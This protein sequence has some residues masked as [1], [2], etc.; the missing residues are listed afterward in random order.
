MRWRLAALAAPLA[1]A[2]A[3]VGTQAAEAASVPT[4]RGINI[5]SVYG[6]QT[7]EQIDRELDLA[8]RLGSNA[9]RLT[10]DSATLEPSPGFADP[11]YLDR[12][13][14]V[15]NAASARGLKVIAVVMGTP[16]WASSAPP[17]VRRDCVNPD[18]F[19]VRYPPA[20]PATYAN[21]ASY[22]AARYRG[23][24]AALEV[25][26]EPDL[27]TRLYWRGPTPAG[28]YAR[29][30]RA[31]YP[32]IKAADPTLPV[33]GGSLVGSNGVFLRQLYAAGIRG[34][35]D[36]LAI[37]F[38]DVV[39]AGIRTIAAIKRTYH[40]T[41]PLWETEFGWDSCGPTGRSPTNL[42]CVTPT[43]QA[44]NLLDVFRGLSLHPALRATIVFNAIDN[45][46]IKFGAL[47]ETFAPK[48][49]FYALQAAFAGRAGAVRSPTMRLFR[50]RGA[51][52]ATGTAPAGD[53]LIVSAFR[54]GARLPAFRAVRIPEGFRHY[55]VRLPYF[56]NSGRW[57]IQAIIPWTGRRREIWIG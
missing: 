39:L 55:L 7:D 13:D 43:Q 31:A 9:V 4:V 49:A 44:S 36:G 37:H 52:Y 24:L 45:P 23:K 56:V 1:L 8:N 42:P 38:Y 30:L 54:A 17:E 2:F 18:P 33:L 15:I 12:V 3:L 34:Y 32:A 16:C 41:T 53:G 14:T 25:W 48:P 11:G 57:L 40:D 19:V 27:N 50:S 20:N 22:V 26:N 29:L 10:I 6:G 47:S 28:S 46:R 5:D 35:Y 21:E 51:V